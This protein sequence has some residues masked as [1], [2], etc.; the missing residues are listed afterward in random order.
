[1]LG[2]HRRTNSVSTAARDANS[3]ARARSSSRHPSHRLRAADSGV[4]RPWRG[5][6]DGG[7]VV[8]VLRGRATVVVGAPRRPGGPPGTPAPREDPAGAV[9]VFGVVVG[10]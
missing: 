4:A 10:A 3:R 6:V 2:S 8:V 1:M 9:P 7:E 5:R